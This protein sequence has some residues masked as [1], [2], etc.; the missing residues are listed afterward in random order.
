MQSFQLLLLRAKNLG[1]V[2]IKINV[3]VWMVLNVPGDV[4][5][6]TRVVA[7]WVVFIHSGD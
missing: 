4:I 7:F 2:Q 5:F 6:L 3:L 1:R